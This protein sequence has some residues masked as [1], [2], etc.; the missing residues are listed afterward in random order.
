MNE[1]AACPVKGGRRSLAFA[2][3]PRDSRLR[4]IAFVTRPPR[5]V[6]HA[7]HATTIVQRLL[8]HPQW[9]GQL[10]RRRW[11]H[12]LTVLFLLERRL[13]FTATATGATWGATF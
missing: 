5:G 12:Q 10:L 6:H 13:L 2:R 3:R 11:L 7:W 8:G 1:Q 9:A 4:P